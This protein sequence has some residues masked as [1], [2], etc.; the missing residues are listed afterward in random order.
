MSIYAFV[1]RGERLSGFST[2]II[3]IDN[4]FAFRYIHKGGIGIFPTRKAGIF[5]I[6]ESML[7]T[8]SGKHCILIQAPGKRIRKPY[9]FNRFSICMR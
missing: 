4:N 3:E 6:N 2:V 9:S 5:I 8:D 1:N 7:S